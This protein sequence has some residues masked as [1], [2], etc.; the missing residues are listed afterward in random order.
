V[1]Q[2]SMSSSSSADIPRHVYV[3]MGEDGAE[4]GGGG[5]GTTAKGDEETRVSVKGVGMLY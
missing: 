4:G 1:T 2:Y 5:D 3:Y